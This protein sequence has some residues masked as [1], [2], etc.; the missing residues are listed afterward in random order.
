MEKKTNERGYA[1]S[2][3]KTTNTA[4]VT[5]Y[6]S[7]HMKIVESIRNLGKLKIKVNGRN[8]FKKGARLTQR[9]YGAGLD[10]ATRLSLVCIMFPLCIHGTTKRRLGRALG[11]ARSESLRSTPKRGRTCGCFNCRHMRISCNTS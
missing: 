1:M 4:Q 8:C 10:V 11:L 5:V 3:V 6:D 9:L 2:W 7:L